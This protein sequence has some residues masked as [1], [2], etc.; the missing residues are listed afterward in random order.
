MLP[1]TKNYRT[2][3]LGAASLWIAAGFCVPGFAAG[4]GS[5]TNNPDLLRGT[6]PASCYDVAFCGPHPKRSTQPVEDDVTVPVYPSYQ[7]SVAPNYR[8]FT[9]SGDLFP[10]TQADWR[11]ALRGAYRVD[12][13]GSSYE[14]VAAPS[15]EFTHKASARE[16]V[17]GASAEIVAPHATS[18][19]VREVEATLNGEIALGR[20]VTGELRANIGISQDDPGS[21]SLPAGVNTAP[22]VVEGGA[23]GVAT[24][25]FGS[26]FTALR[27]SIVREQYGASGL[28]AGGTQSN[29]D[30][31][32]TG[33]ETGLRLGTEVAAHL[34]AF[35]EG[36]VR[37]DLYDAA[38]RTYGVKAD[39]W[40]YIAKT[41]L[42]G[43]WHDVLTGEVSVGYTYRNYDNG[44]FGNVHAAL[45]D[46]SVTYNPDETVAITTS[47]GTELTA[48]DPLTGATSTINYTA[49]ID[50]SYLINERLTLRGQLGAELALLRNTGQTETEFSAGTGAD[51]ALNPHTDLNA[52]YDYVH[53]N[54]V[55]GASDSHT[56]SLGVSFKR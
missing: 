50:A 33:L 18:V 35:I 19:R 44:V 34:D 14:I 31:N 20:D 49:G 29:T 41:G 38:S 39:S 48:D 2:L 56:V 36:A 9:P 21:S 10:S 42:T 30:R 17:F 11:L 1:R 40:S 47:V 8:E 13:S 43:N 45:A 46:A 26:F 25:R 24:R 32:R 55:S 4:E 6:M 23:E 12:S 28:A 5:K 53:A 15:V 7:Q 51:F 27:G 37:R 52:D 22:I 54:R 3:M 16:V